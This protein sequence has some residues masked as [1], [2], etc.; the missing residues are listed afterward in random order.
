MWS[1]KQGSIWGVLWISERS[2]SHLWEPKKEGTMRLS[3]VSNWFKR[4]K[5]GIFHSNVIALSGNYVHREGVITLFICLLVE[6]A[7]EQ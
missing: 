4:W 2:Q 7:Q 6:W 1:P 5:F 3:T